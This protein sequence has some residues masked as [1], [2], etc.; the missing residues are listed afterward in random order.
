VKL[1]IQCAY[2]CVNLFGRS[3]GTWERNLI[4]WNIGLSLKLGSVDGDMNCSV[5]TI[6]FCLPCHFM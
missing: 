4:S 1:L 3:W 2:C 5:I 6:F